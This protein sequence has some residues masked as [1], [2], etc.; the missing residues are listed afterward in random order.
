[1]CILH[2]YTPKI[3]ATP[4]LDLLPS[5]SSPETEGRLCIAIAIAIAAVTQFPLVG[6][7]EPWQGGLN[8]CE[9]PGIL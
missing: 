5:I 8:C 2:A 1:M 6:N 3:P 4:G 9:H 7:T